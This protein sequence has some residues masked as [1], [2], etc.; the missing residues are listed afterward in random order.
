MRI[1][2][3]I[4]LFSLLE[5]FSPATQAAGLPLVISATVDYTHSTLTITGQNFGSVPAVTL[6]SLMFP[7]QNSTG[8]Q[9]VANF[10]S[11]KTPSNFT[12]GTYFLTVTFKNQLPTIFG[13]DIGANG[14]PGPAG[15]AGTQGLPGVTGAAGPAGPAGPLGLPGPV[16]PPGATGPIGAAGAQGLQGVMG[17]VG[18]QGSQGATGASGATGP[19]GPPGAQ[20]GLPTC[21]APDVIVLYSGAFVCKSAVPHFVD[22]GDGTVTDNQTGLMW[23][24]KTGT[25]S[26]DNCCR[27]DPH[28]VNNTYYWSNPT[29]SADIAADGTL[30][31]S[32]LAILNSDVSPDGLS[33]CFANHC[34]WRIPNVVEFST[35]ID[36]VAPGCNSGSPCIDP[37]FGPTNALG[38]VFGYFSSTTYGFGYTNFVWDVEFQGGGTTA[39]YK[40]NPG[41]GRAVRSAR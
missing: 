21:A 23:E 35:I 4:S 24:Q 29:I 37:V 19:Q 17:A 38:L 36:S 40:Q 15:P 16:G 18:P 14:A 33:T 5:I 8:S 13:V 9:I 34:D 27:T 20:G 11:G 41:Y 22:N 31:T 30:Y 2:A 3:A 39:N 28:D 25:F 1:F 7:T 26:A 12:P 10:P 32:F 6:D